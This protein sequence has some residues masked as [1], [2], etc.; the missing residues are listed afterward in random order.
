M[1]IRTAGAPIWVSGVKSLGCTPVSL[2]Y[3]DMYNGIQTKV[4]DGCELP[5]IAANNLKIQEVTKYILE[6]RHFY[7]NNFMVCSAEWFNKLPAEY[8]TILL[9]ECNK[10]GLEVSEQMEKDT[11]AAKQAMIDA[12]MEYIPYDQMDIA[13]F[14]E[15]SKKAYEELGLIEARDAIFAEL[16]R[17]AE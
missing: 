7:Q 14:K 15:S 8:Q 11:D 3:G 17:S 1:Q 13:A 16:G 2:P 6:T 12:G 10:A 4:V 9:D 5:Y